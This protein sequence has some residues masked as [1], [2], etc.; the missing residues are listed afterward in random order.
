MELRYIVKAVV[1]PPFCQILLLIFAFKVRRSMPR[2]GKLL[3]IFAVLSLWIL[4]TPVASNHLARL[5]IEDQPLTPDKLAQQQ[6]DAIVV[7][8]ASQNQ[9]ADEFG[10]PVSG[11]DTLVR[12]RYG[13]YLHRVT[14]LPMLLAGGSVHG[15]EQRSLAETMAF[16]L[17]ESFGVEARWLEQKSRT[18]AENA[19]LSYAMLGKEGKTSIL[20][21]TSALHMRR[22]KWS[23]IQAGY[24]VIPA[25]TDFIDMKPLAIASFLPRAHSLSLSSDALHEW[26]GYLVYHVLY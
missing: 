15:N 4:A 14:G 19:A 11:Q 5:L 8:S 26:L 20:L 7:L 2:S 22:A 24:E 21:V 13:A 3:G 23:F 6:A 1:L 18:T 17:S 12:L 10:E 9:A 25:P 16:D